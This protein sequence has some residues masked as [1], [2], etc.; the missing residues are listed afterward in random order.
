MVYVMQYTGN[1]ASSAPGERAQ[2]K[3]QGSAR[4]TIL[5]KFIAYLFCIL[6]G[7]LFLDFVG[8]IQG[9]RN[10]NVFLQQSSN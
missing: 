3:Y 10:N 2:N 5:K 6:D 8:T 4:I 1:A 7:K 9:W